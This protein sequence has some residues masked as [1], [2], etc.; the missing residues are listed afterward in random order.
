M[1]AALPLRLELSP[2]ERPVIIF[3]KKHSATSATE[4]QEAVS[5][6]VIA[7]MVS[8]RVIE[9][10]TYLTIEEQNARRRYGHSV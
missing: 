6:L 2:V 5:T 10:M 9:T 1:A 3:M 7:T 8:V 4:A